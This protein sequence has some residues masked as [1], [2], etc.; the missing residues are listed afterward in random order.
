MKQNNMKRI[1]IIIVISFTTLI[2]GQ[3]PH[4]FSHNNITDSSVTLSWIGNGC[5]SFKLKYR[6]SGGIWSPTINN[7]T[8]PYVLKNLIPNT[9]YEW[10]VKCIGLNGWPISDAITTICNKSV[11]QSLSGFDINP[12]YDKW[13]WTYDTLS[14]INTSNCDIRIRPEFNISHDSLPI[15]IND[16]DLKWYNPY[17]GN[18]PNLEYEID[19]NGNAIGFWSYGSDTTGTNITQGTTQ[20]VIIKLRFRN[21]A[22][23]GKYTANWQTKEVD[24][25]GNSLQTLGLG[26]TTSID[27]VDCTIF[28]T[29]SVNITNISCYGANN[30][31]V[32][33]VSVKNGSGTTTYN[34]SNGDNTNITQNLSPGEYQCII[35]DSIW[36]ECID[37]ISFTIT[38][39]AEIGATF[40]GIDNQDGVDIVNLLCNGLP[41]GKIDAS[42]ASG[43]A[44][45]V[46]IQYTWQSTASGLIKRKVY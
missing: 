20:K 26:L 29:D 38:E 4:S 17:I 1:L 30:G 40:I 19:A 33:I 10:T 34:W 44:P 12:I 28:N 23:Y 15:N 6:E 41:T 7:I 9:S 37:T 36:L 14:I 27:L 46:N 43:S 21:N 2:Y 5:S 32:N 16:F 25:F 13:L 42:G 18:W 45:S 3:H 39:P 8:P 22:N 24:N 31:A 35:K 11:T